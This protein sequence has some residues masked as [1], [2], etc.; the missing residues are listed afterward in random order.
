MKTRVLLLGCLLALAGLVQAAETHREIW[1]WTDANGVKHYSDS[2]A[3]GARRV[4]V[5]GQ[6]NI[7][8]VAP[9]PSP[10]TGARPATGQKAPAVEYSV[11][12]IYTPENNT[13]FFTPDVVVDVRLRSDPDLAPDDKLVT[14]FDG[15]P[16]E[17]GENSYSHSF[18]N[19]E[20]GGHTVIG[21]IYDAHGKEKIRSEPLIF[22]MK[23]PNETNLRNV[24]PSLRPPPPQAQPRPGTGRPGG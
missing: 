6:P 3:P 5:S 23:L 14:Y 22:W 24:G 19:L 1:V 20:R 7:G 9:V 15:K 21:V 2:P 17:G 18:S 16:V 4:V 11:L 13:S 8:T 12:E 10:D